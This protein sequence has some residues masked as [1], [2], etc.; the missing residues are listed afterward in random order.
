MVLWWNLL[1]THL[2]CVGN[3]QVKDHL[4]ATASGSSHVWT[5]YANM[6]KRYTRMRIFLQNRWQ[7][8]ARDTT[9][10]MDDQAVYDMEQG[11]GH[12]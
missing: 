8:R 9:R 11:T 5:I 4:L 3:I 7:H 10:V 1:L 12:Q 2:L 6:R